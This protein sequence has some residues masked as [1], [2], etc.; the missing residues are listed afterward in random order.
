MKG[1]L[2]MKKSKKLIAVLSASAIALSFSLSTALATV[3]PNDNSDKEITITDKSTIVED[4]VSDKADRPLLRSS[5]LAVSQSLSSSTGSESVTFDTTKNYPYYRIYVK[6]NSKVNY[7]MVTPGGTYTIAAGGSQTIWTT[8]ATSA[9][10]YKVSVTSSD[11]SKLKGDIA[12][13]VAST[14]AEVKQ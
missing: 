14:H 11:G 6:N 10:T 8:Q 12:I 7:T 13:R 2:K 1:M 4:S 5:Y 3:E 9:N